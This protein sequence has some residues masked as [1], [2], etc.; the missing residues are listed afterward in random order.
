MPTIAEKY[1]DNSL[2]GLF[3]SSHADKHGS[4]N[5]DPFDLGYYCLHVFSYFDLINNATLVGW[6]I[7]IFTTEDPRE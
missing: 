7:A 5:Y 2:A 1:L 6:E 3:P 4:A